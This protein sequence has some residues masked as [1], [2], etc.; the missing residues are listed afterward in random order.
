MRPLLEICVDSAEGLRAAVESGAGRIE[1]C[2]ALALSGLTPSAGLMAIAA[3]YSTPIHA[4]IRPRGGDFVHGADELDTM[5]RDIDAVRRAGLPGVVLGVSRPNGELDGDKLHMLMREASGLGVT[6]HRA[7]DIVPDLSAALEMAID[8]G[9]DR[10][11][12]SGGAATALAGADRIADLVAQ[13]SDRIIIMAGAGVT[14]DNVADLIDR[15]GVNEVHASCG[16]PGAG[17][18]AADDD[19]NARLDLILGQ[20]AHAGKHTSALKVREM[21]TALD[22]YAQA[23]SGQSDSLLVSSKGS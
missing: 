2:S 18:A 16:A 14:A 13:A 3:A 15:T 8:L 21:I 17:V 5:R 7:F 12:T 1:L 19:L 4:M 6:L 10:I 11:L 9:F 20:G 22:R 23:R